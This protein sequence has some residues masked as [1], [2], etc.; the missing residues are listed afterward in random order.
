MPDAEFHFDFASPNAYFCHVVL[1]AIEHRTGARFTYVPVLLGGIF[2]LTNNRAPMVAF[3]EVRNKL[4]YQRLEIRRFI[5]DHG[6]TRF[7]FN[8]HFPVNTLLLMRAAV[9]AQLEGC[10]DAYVAAAFHHMWE[11]PKKLD[12]PEVAHAAL[13]ES[14]LDA[15]LLLRRAGD[16]D[17]K[18]T[19]AHKTARSVERGTFGAPTFYVGDEI[20]FGKDSLPALEREITRQRTA[21]AA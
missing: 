9:A 21:D 14:G 6:L 8:P 13:T 20:F 11:A 1:P 4:D 7:N 10:L 18:D 19:L 16:A 12:D 2:K 3:A 15:A 5:R 17:V